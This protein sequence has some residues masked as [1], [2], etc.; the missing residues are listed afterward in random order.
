M[1]RTLTEEFI[2]DNEDITDQNTVANKN[3]IALLTIRQAS[4]KK[5]IAFK[6]V[7]HSRNVVNLNPLFCVFEIYIETKWV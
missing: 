7:P 6:M 4:F 5:N 3:M 2:C 1:H